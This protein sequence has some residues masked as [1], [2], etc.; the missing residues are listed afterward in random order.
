VA[1]V[2]NEPVTPKGAASAMLSAYDVYYRLEGPRE[3]TYHSARA[4]G[5]YPPPFLSKLTADHMEQGKVLTVITEED[6]RTATARKS[7]R[8]RG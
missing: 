7:R 1:R 4:Y 8:K 6:Y 3:T 5:P 2:N